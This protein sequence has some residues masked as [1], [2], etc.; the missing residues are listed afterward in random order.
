MADLNQQILLELRDMNQNMRRQSGS[1]GGSGAANAGNQIAAERK[2]RTSGE[3]EA[4]TNAVE[5]IQAAMTSGAR[6]FVGTMTDSAENVARAQEVTSQRNQRL[7]ASVHASWKSGQIQQH[8]AVEKMEEY[9][10]TMEMLSMSTDEL[11]ANFVNA[12]QAAE[13]YSQAFNVAATG[14][15]ESLDTTESAF[16]RFQTVSL[17]GLSG[18]VLQN[19]GAFNMLR[20]GTDLL[21]QGIKAAYEALDKSLVTGIN[22]SA[23][24]FRDGLLMG[25]NRGDLVDTMA[26]YRQTLEGAE[27]TTAGFQAMMKAS[28]HEM[29]GFGMGLK[30]GAVLAAEAASQY[31]NAAG[32]GANLVDQATFLDKQQEVYKSLYKSIGMTTE[33]F[34]EMTKAIDTSQEV[35]TQ[36]FKLEKSKRAGYKADL[37][38][39]QKQ[40]MLDGLSLQQA[41][42]LVDKL[43]ALSGQ[44]GKSRLK[45]A[46]KAQAAFGAVGMGADGERVAQLIRTGARGEGEQSELKGLMQTFREATGEMQGSG[47]MG[48]E[49]YADAILKVAGME[50]IMKSLEP[51]IMQQGKAVADA[52]S[53]NT[54][55][56]AD[57]IN[58]L[59]HEVSMA[60]AMMV[61]AGLKNAA[62]NPM[63]VALMAVGYG[64]K[65][66]AGAG[67]MISDTITRNVG[68]LINWMELYVSTAKLTLTVFRNGIMNIVDTFKN[69]FSILGGIFEIMGNNIREGFKEAIGNIYGVDDYEGQYKQ[70]RDVVDSGPSKERIQRDKEL[71]TQFDKLTTSFQSLKDSRDAARD[72][73]EK[74]RAADAKEQTELMKQMVENQ[75]QTVDAV[76]TNTTATKTAGKDTI[77]TLTETNDKLEEGNNK[78]KTDFSGFR[79]VRG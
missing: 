72:S 37:L 74:K 9:G 14:V 42:A 62:E 51:A 64:G 48:Q 24:Q 3:A 73:H 77:N 43:N 29:F 1:F 11:T 57:S 20:T 26:D 5:S 60:T 75:K 31:R 69:S 19:I 78:K 4:F 25:M 65:F 68:N 79:A 34:A 28:S 39:S 61:A 30:G 13:A 15:T 71:T 66:M 27:Q 23:D 21:Y 47:D 41:G 59:G 7:M 53:I 10:G 2:N 49:L 58:V 36:L 50:D 45:Q 33:K 44:D 17:G 63:D 8:V 6:G 18:T 38:L 76:E 35:Q 22:V 16:Q 55:K 32:S 54:T 12:S 67:E 56:I 52:V 40:Y 46:A 70:F